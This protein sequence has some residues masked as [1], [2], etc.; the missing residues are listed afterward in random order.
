M[1]IAKVILLKGVSSAGLSRLKYSEV[2][3]SAGALSRL[4]PLSLL[5]GM[6]GSCEVGDTS[7]P[8]L[9][10][11]GVSGAVKRLAVAVGVVA[12]A[13]AA[14]GGGSSVAWTA[15]GMLLALAP[16]RLLSPSRFPAFCWPSVLWWAACAR[17]CSAAAAFA[18][19]AVFLPTL[20]RE[21]RCRSRSARF[22]VASMAG[23]QR[24]RQARTDMHEERDERLA[25]VVVVVECWQMEEPSSSLGSAAEVEAVVGG[26]MAWALSRATI[27]GVEVCMY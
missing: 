1:G 10:V 16:A 12:S 19:G 6:E 5:E 9:G 7:D 24:G 20:R 25:V 14:G 13:A 15:A 27:E 18:L 23:E 3:V 22:L 11:S 26:A 17:S 4:A 8:G 2:G 21:A